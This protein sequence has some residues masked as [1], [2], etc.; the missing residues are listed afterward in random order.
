VLAGGG[1]NLRATPH[2]GLRVEAD[3]LRTKLANTT[4]KVQNSV[5]AGV[6]IVFRF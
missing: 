4:T 2:V 1:T 5:R 3:W 6:C